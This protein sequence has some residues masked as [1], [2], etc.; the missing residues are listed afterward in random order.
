[1]NMNYKPL[2]TCAIVV[3]LGVG[4]VAMLAIPVEGIALS[5]WFALFLVSKAV[6]IGAISMAMWLLTRQIHDEDI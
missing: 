2:I 4:I 5:R 3:L 6:G 1:M